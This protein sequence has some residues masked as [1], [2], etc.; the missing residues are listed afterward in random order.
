MADGMQ[1]MEVGKKVGHL[2]MPLLPT[3]PPWQTSIPSQTA[4]SG[5]QKI[6]HGSAMDAI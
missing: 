6:S 1:N 4:Y 3:M 5:F 2:N